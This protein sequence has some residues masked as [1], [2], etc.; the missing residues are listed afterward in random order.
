[1][2]GWVIV[3]WVCCL[4]P[5]TGFL[6]AVRCCSVGVVIFISKKLPYDTSR[7]QQLLLLL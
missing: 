1:M 6:R 3:Y 4:L 7:F 5:F 2:W